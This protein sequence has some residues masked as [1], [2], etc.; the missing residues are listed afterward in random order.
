MKDVKYELINHKIKTILGKQ[1]AFS[2]LTK[3][4]AVIKPTGEFTFSYALRF[5]TMAALEEFL[6]NYD[7]VQILK[8]QED[9]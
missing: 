7:Y 1:F 4:V 2:K 5:K 3:G 9:K 8:N 6:Y